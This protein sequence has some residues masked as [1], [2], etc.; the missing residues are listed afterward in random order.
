MKK[1]NHQKAKSKKPKAKPARKKVAAKNVKQVKPK[2]TKAKEPVIEKK[3][4]FKP[5][6]DKLSVMRQ[7][8]VT[9]L[10][11]FEALP[12]DQVR[13]IVQQQIPVSLS[14]EFAVYFDYVFRL[15]SRYRL[16]EEVPDRVPVHIRL[17]QR[18]DE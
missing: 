2:A 11:Q 4:P 1:A 16:L 15:L 17:A 12:P 3:P 8:L 7:T 5:D 14:D 18:L 9:T 10:W 6:P 13:E